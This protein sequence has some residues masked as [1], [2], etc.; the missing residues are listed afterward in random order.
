ME[1]REREE[2][3]QIAHFKAN[4]YRH[5]RGSIQ[6]AKGKFTVAAETEETSTAEVTSVTTL[7]KDII[8]EPICKRIKKALKKKKQ[9]RETWKEH[10]PIFDDEDAWNKL[11]DQ[12]GN[13][14]IPISDNGRPWKYAVF[15]TLGSHCKYRGGKPYNTY[16]PIPTRSY[17]VSIFKSCIQYKSGIFGAF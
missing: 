12:V 5:K 1:V 8:T 3:A 9:P 17:E 6:Y 13:G 16:P 2:Q 11:Y 15:R 14:W 7:K 10:N 4:R